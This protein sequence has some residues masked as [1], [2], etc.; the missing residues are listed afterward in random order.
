M[1]QELST[2]I[3]TVVMETFLEWKFGVNS[4]DRCFLLGTVAKPEIFEGK[5]EFVVLSRIRASQF[6]D[7][8]GTVEFRFCGPQSYAYDWEAM[9]R[10]VNKALEVLGHM[11]LSQMTNCSYTL[12]LIVSESQ[13]MD[14][15]QFAKRAISLVSEV[16]KLFV[17]HY[18]GGVVRAFDFPLPIMSIVPQVKSK[19]L[20]AL[21]DEP[22]Y[23][24]LG[25]YLA[26]R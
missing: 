9:A 13:G 6:P 19:G 17:W 21:T 2:Q 5:K 23:L 11:I 1:T 26:S 10:G 24:N 25:K 3:P 15:T 8:S 20:D 4:K 22:Q 14:Y 18:V 12:R 7:K 16:Q